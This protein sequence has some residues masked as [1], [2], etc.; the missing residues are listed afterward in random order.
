[1]YIVQSCEEVASTQVKI[2]KIEICHHM[3]PRNPNDKAGKELGVDQGDVG[4]QQAQLLQCDLSLQE[5]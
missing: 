2:A 3:N 5:G 4:S 1:M